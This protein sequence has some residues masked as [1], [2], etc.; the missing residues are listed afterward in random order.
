MNILTEHTTMDFLFAQWKEK[1]GRDYLPYRNHAYRVYNIASTLAKV[2]NEDNEKIAVASAFHDIGIWFDAT[3][4]YLDPSAQRAEHYLINLGKESWT[5]TVNLMILQHHKLFPWQ[6]QGAESFLVEA[7]RRA[8]WL[9]V[10]CF[11]LP[12]RLPEAYLCEVVKAFPRVG[13]NTRITSLAL[14]WAIRHPLKP[15]PIFRW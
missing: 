8:D 9:D 10:A 5:R 4:D 2:D 14:W 6:G 7:F 15:L 13:F 3:F 12:T 11:F 1:L